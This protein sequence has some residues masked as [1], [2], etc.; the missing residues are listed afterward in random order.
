MSKDSNSQEHKKLI[1]Y[2]NELREDIIK[3]LSLNADSS[4]KN[5]PAEVVAEIIT[6]WGKKKATANGGE[7]TADNINMMYY[8]GGRLLNE[9]TDALLAPEIAREIAAKPENEAAIRQ[10]AADLKEENRELLKKVVDAHIAM[11]APGKKPK[12]DDAVI[13]RRVQEAWAEIQKAYLNLEALKPY[14]LTGAELNKFR[15]IIKQ[16]EDRMPP[17]FELLVSETCWNSALEAL[18][19][20]M[21][22]SEWKT[23]RDLSKDGERDQGRGL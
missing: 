16:Q 7:L 23:Y 10:E 4:N 8:A 2:V 9:L 5:D 22:H 1:S 19:G 14:K 17:S 15:E 12:I 21:R 6:E 18:Q 11:I 20:K 3:E 13:E